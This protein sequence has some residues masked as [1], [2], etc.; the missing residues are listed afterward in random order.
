[1]SVDKERWRVV[2]PYLDHALELTGGERAAWLASLRHAD[3]ALAA[4]LES[5]L[6]EH[7]ALDQEGFLAGAPPARPPRTSPAGQ[8]MGPYTLRSL[9]GQGGMGG[10][11]LA[12]RSDG[13]FEG[14][15]AI[16]L[17]NAS[18]VGRDGEG[19]FKREGSI[20]GRLRHPHIA[21]LIDAGVSP[22]GQPF[23]VLEHVEGERIDHYCDAR[24]LGIEA[25]VR[26]FLDVLAAVAH[27]HANLVVHR[28]LK[29]S[30]VLVTRDGQ[31]KLLDFGIAKMLEDEAGQVT[32]LTRE[33]RSAL[34]PEYAAPEQLTGGDITTATDVY[35]LG[36]LLYTLLSGRHPAGPEAGS[37]AGLVRAIVETEP[38]RLSDTASDP[39][40]AHPSPAEL[41]GRR[42]ATPKRLRSLLQGDLDNIVAK[43][44][45][46]VP[47][48]RYASV[49]ALADDLRR[50][51][52]H[53]PVRARADSFR[54]RTA[55]FAR[56][57]RVALYLSG[58]AFV[59]LA[60]GVV[61][62]V[63][64]AR[65]ATRQALRADAEARTASEQRDFALRQL[66]RA[67]A[68]NDLN[69]FLLRDAAPMG[70]PFTAGELLAR[71]ET[72]V[73]RQPDDGNRVDML[74][75]IGWQFL[76]QQQEDR[77]RQILG[78][79][80]EL[81][82]RS[83]DPATRAKAACALASAIALAGEGVRAEQLVHE[84]ETQLPREPQFALQRIQC[85]LSG[86]DVAKELGNL[87]AAVDRAQAAQRLLTESRF[88]SAPLELTVSA[89]LADAY[90]LAGRYREADVAFRQ[91]FARLA[92]LGRDR[93]NMAAD[94][95]NDWG[96]TMRGLGQM[97]EAERLLRTAIQID[98][99]DATEDRVSPMLMINLARV[100]RDLE[101]LPESAHYAERAYA[102]ARRSGE[103]V[104]INQAL[105]VRAA[106]YR[107]QGAFER[108][109]AALDELEPRLQRLLPP[110]D[111]QFSTLAMER[112]Q[113][114]S[115]RGDE[116][117]AL[118]GADHAV[119]LAEAGS[120]QQPQYLKRLLVARSGLNL[121]ARHLDQAAA[122]AARAVRLEAQGAA[123][124]LFSSGLGLAY[125]ALARA[126]QAQGRLSE[127]QAAV[128]S[129]VD[130]LVPSLG[131]DHPA[132]RTA[133]EL[134]GLPAAKGNR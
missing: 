115:A 121:Q 37:T 20:L 92:A 104:V 90:R 49:D 55:K 109:Q 68:I 45:K 29:P 28:D 54:Y 123:P 124:G 24:R 4:D 27:A 120:R 127:A 44:L 43:A 71:A 128:A 134:A 72:I 31:V 42:G 69:S 88:V 9:L 25:R 95:L 86:S 98:S 87:R 18:L 130:H 108:A 73:E 107:Q 102:S 1:V 85:L 12:E 99:A 132:T 36:V 117:A 112:A 17:L 64:Q 70:K 53:R 58:L 8:V 48:E 38:P 47:G 105:F 78:K 41:A 66:L 21:Q 51:L 111:L 126:L 113:L 125:L 79:A 82:R 106:V 61:G 89:R 15:A 94:L 119:A 22:S 118:S 2:S 5:L 13:R 63:S 65:R 62:T 57:N 26:L 23:L 3:E 52:A 83:T 50:Y 101:R 116:I 84:A 32:A 56:R 74:V 11:W 131:A 77:A 81:A 35:A 7:D 129:A 19:R 103:E 39:A 10:V 76:L 67:E 93:T 34:T 96:L 59:A 40:P 110:G 46:K 133:R 14:V 30:N 6:R 33:G 100:L 75:Q 91:A 122:D 114:A 16:K 60:A 80:D 97:L